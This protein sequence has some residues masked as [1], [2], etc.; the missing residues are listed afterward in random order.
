MDLLLLFSR[1]QNRL[2]FAPTIII[3]IFS[4]CLFSSFKG[5]RVQFTG[6]VK[7]PRVHHGVRWRRT[8][9]RHHVLLAGRVPLLLD[10][11]FYTDLLVR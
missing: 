1:A 3:I 6:V 8:S 9:T 10:K 11:G 5:E 2:H 4:T 7:A